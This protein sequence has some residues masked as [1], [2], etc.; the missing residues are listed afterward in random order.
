MSD[1]QEQPY[2][3]FLQTDIDAFSLVLRFKPS[4]ALIHRAL[5]LSAKRLESEKGINV[6]V[7]LGDASKMLENFILPPAFN[8][9]FGTFAKKV[10]KTIFAEVEKDGIEVVHNKVNRVLYSKEGDQWFITYECTGQMIKK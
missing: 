2:Y 6:N 4:G 8:N 1:K 7:R 10:F 5:K 9:L 3:K